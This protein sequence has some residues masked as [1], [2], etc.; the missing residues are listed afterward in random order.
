MVGEGGVAHLSKPPEPKLNLVK[1]D[2]LADA[3]APHKN[4][5]V[6]KRKIVSGREV[7]T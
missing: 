1:S 2:L 4:T 6:Y 7:E 3:E 5:V